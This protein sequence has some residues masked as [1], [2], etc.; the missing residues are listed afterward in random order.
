MLSKL[1][2]KQRRSASPSTQMKER[3]YAAHES[4][5]QFTVDAGLKVWVDKAESVRITDNVV[6]PT[7]ALAHAPVIEQ[8]LITLTSFF[9]D[10]NSPLDVPLANNKFNQS[11]SE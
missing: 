10:H 8:F 9:F 4:T 2:S 7:L 5:N 3:L 1:N 6:R 11:V